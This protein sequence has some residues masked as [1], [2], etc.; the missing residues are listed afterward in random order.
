MSQT[1]YLRNASGYAHRRRAVVVV[2]VAILSAL[3]I[4]FAALAVDIGIIYNARQELR[5][6]VDASAMAGAA[7]LAKAPIDPD[8][9]AG[10]D[11]RDFGRAEEMAISTA[12]QNKVTG[13]FLHVDGDDV[14]FGWAEPGATG[15][16]YSFS[17]D[18]SDVNAV[19]VT[20]RRT[21]DNAVNGP[22]DL[23]F[24]AIFGIRTND[25]VAS[26]TALMQPRDIAIVADLS[27]SHNNDSE[28]RSLNDLEINLG[29]VW[30]ELPGG[31]DDAP[32]LWAGWTSSDPLAQ[33]WAWGFFQR[34]P[35]GQSF[36][37]GFGYD[38]NSES[39]PTQH[40][41]KDTYEPNTD[42]GLIHMEFTATAQD[43]IPVGGTPYGEM[44]D[45]LTDTMG[46]KLG[47]LN[48]TDGAF[49]PPAPTDEQSE[50]YAIMG[51]HANGET[52]RLYNWLFRTAVATGYAEWNSGI[53]GGRWE[54]AGMPAPP[55]PPNGD[56]KVD[57]WELVWGSATLGSRSP[58][59]MAY[60]WFDYTLDYL[61]VD[62]TSMVVYGHPDFQW[63]FG[64]KTFANYLLEARPRYADTPELFETPHQ[65]VEA[66]KGAVQ[67]LGAAL[68]ADYGDLMSLEVY[69]TSVTHEV[70]LTSDVSAVPTR[71]NEM[72]A[73][74]YDGYTN[75]GGGIREGRNT[76]TGS[77]SRPGATR[78][79]VLL[80]D[81]RATAWENLTEH[82]P[83]GTPVGEPMR[84]NLGP[85]LEVA[86][87]YAVDQAAWAG[88]EGIQVY[89]VSLGAT[90]DVELMD[91]IAEVTNG[92]HYH[93]EG[94]SIE[95]YAA[96]LVQVFE[97]IAVVRP[98]TLVQ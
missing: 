65:P 61:A 12:G 46:Y 56:H 80:S 18:G 60:L 13:E 72:Q 26:A 94:D 9:P 95:D 40:I 90:A 93:V 8:A 36:G 49:D 51:D 27:A 34:N 6:A 32:G 3:L 66:E 43:W 20:G 48:I 35:S 23:V 11:P 75:I 98:V 67:S 37:K 53:P 15:P 71:L 50:I 24:A 92:R 28:L 39:G 81:G 97:E 79:L 76:L 47:D 78:I 83:S 22:V 2:K 74:H 64:P 1:S 38:V 29:E 54:T 45:Y 25:M 82:G 86:R 88:Q 63:K 96:K 57:P 59:E 19:R 77:N 73:G 58:Y 89:A 44:K 31:V 62:Y 17:A 16:A 70:D 41:D 7:M 14:E 69:A 5:R 30:S 68:R 84:A 55:F 87:Q 4:G 21:E 91:E 42:N 52:G 33:G 85:T 10:E